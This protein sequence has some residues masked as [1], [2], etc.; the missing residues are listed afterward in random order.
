MKTEA[1]RNFLDNKRAEEFNKT[2]GNAGYVYEYVNLNKFPDGTFYFRFV[3][4]HTEKCPKGYFILSTHSIQGVKGEYPDRVSCTETHAPGKPCAICDL[5]EYTKKKK[6]LPKLPSSLREQFDKNLKPFRRIMIPLGFYADIESNKDEESGKKTVKITA[7]P[8]RKQEQG[9]ILTVW[10]KSVIEDLLEIL[11]EYP[12]IGDPDDGR[13]IK[14]RKKG[15]QYR[16]T[17]SKRRPLKNKALLKQYPNFAENNEDNIH[18]Y[19]SLKLML[20]GA[21]FWDRLKHYIKLSEITPKKMKALRK[22]GHSTMAAMEGGKKKKKKSALKKKKKRNIPIE[23][24][25]D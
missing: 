12:E 19:T 13:L 16:F 7:N 11:E 15:N 1:L 6:V 25:E 23:F 3:G 20:K 24:E 10:Q 5:L 22:A 21:Y 4:P 8:N 18:D 9:V 17:V 2:Y 14:M